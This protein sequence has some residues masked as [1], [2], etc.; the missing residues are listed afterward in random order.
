MS[1]PGTNP[2]DAVVAMRS[3]PRRYRA[4]LLPVDE[5]VVE[6]RAVTIGPGGVSATDL[7]ADT[8][9]SLTLLERALHEVLVA[10]EPVLHPAIADRAARHWE[11]AVSE[12]PQSVLAQL[13]DR[14]ESFAAAIE[15]TDASEWTRGGVSAGR[16]ISALDLVREAVD[17][18]ASNLREMTA[19]LASLD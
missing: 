10:D 8:L 13:D 2:T 17:T 16:R 19:L 11:A 15:R 3:W 1:S 12:S 9:R 4:E 18:A 5:P 7:A 14:A 6:T